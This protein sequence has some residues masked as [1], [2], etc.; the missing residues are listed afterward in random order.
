MK[1][2]GMATKISFIVVMC[3]IVTVLTIA[4][5]NG[6]TMRT[7]LFESSDD[8]LE[9]MCTL[10]SE[11]FEQWLGEQAGMVH[12]M[13]KSMES[14]NDTNHEMLMDYLEKQLKENNSALMYYICFAYDKSV[15]PADHSSL[16][17]DPTERGWWKE[18]VASGHLIYTDPYT[19]FATGKMVV[20]IAEPLVID[21]KQAVILADITIDSLVKMLDEIGDDQYIQA[22]LVTEDGAV[23]AHKN[24]E[25]LPSAEGNVILTEQISIKLDTN[26]LQVIT[27]YDAKEK[28][29]VLK[30]I[31][32][33]GWKLGIAE[34]TTAVYKQ[35]NGAILKSFGVCILVAVVCMSFVILVVGRMLAPLRKAADRVQAISKGDFSNRTEDTQ[36][37]DEIGVLQNAVHHLENNIAGVIQDSNRV[38]GAMASY[39]LTQSRMAAYEGEFNHMA[40]SVNK[41]Q[42]TM[43]EMI[44]QIQVSSAEVNVGSRELS[45][46]AESL[47]RMTLEQA[48]SI[49]SLENEVE[50]MNGGFQRNAENC[51]L[52]DGKLQKL[53]GNIQEGHA[54]MTELLAMVAQ[55]ESF[56]NDIKKIVA[57]I[58]TIAFQT[59][60]LALN[61]SVEAARAGDQGLG[62]AVVAEEVRNLAYRCGE[63]S[64]RTEE[65]IENCMKSIEDV[66][67]C[68]D[69]T[70]G[71]LQGV[72]TDSTEIAGT[73]REIA[74]E[75]NGLSKRVNLM[76]D[77]IAKVSSG[78]QSNMSTS[79]ETA[80]ASVQL[81]EQADNMNQLVAGFRI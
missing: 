66:K 37:G 60:I 16:D 62:F 77:E 61:A 30:T 28:H 1:K 5:V 54:D 26:Q 11:V 6:L 76:V 24:E 36:R 7:A 68:A 34:D 51:D 32:S 23:I 52:V 45:S 39:D 72:A 8:K 17:L 19:D 46:A 57:V 56:S 64:K 53:N 41:I 74:E 80:A 58:D 44:Q 48:S 71:C 65:L 67:K 47:S 38:L 18:A 43:Q 4:L 22:F 79:E 13:A 63:E 49:Q 2:L 81:A 29:M 69:H 42:Q 20:T 31:A 50:N 59:N 40:T 15:N 14:M 75:T 33:T 10:Q 21:E 35:I 55:V 25:F 12:T 27:D 78:I 9:S 73:F 70:F 3:I